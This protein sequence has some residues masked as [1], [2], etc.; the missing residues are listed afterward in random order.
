[1]A[2]LVPIPPSKI[3]GDPLYDAR[4]EKVC[5]RIGSEIDVRSIIKQKASTVAAHE[6]GAAR[7]SV[8]TVLANYEFDE[9]LVDP[10]PQVIGLVDDVLTAG[11]HFRAMKLKLQ[12]RWPD[13]GVIGI[14][15]ARRVFATPDLFES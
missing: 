2:T 10:K 4:M 11:T 15:I 3:P 6:A 14:F 1:M 5:R 9:T 8:E 12:E 13:V 7:P